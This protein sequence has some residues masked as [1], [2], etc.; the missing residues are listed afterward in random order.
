MAIGDKFTYS[1]LNAG[2]LKK[3][4]DMADK[5]YGTG[6]GGGGSGGGN[7]GQ[8]LALSGDS[9]LNSYNSLR[10][11]R[12]GSNQADAAWAASGIAVWANA[13]MGWPFEIIEPTRIGGGKIQHIIH[14][15]KYY[16]E[17]QRPDWVFTLAGANDITSN[18][19]YAEMIND[20]KTLI[21]KHLRTTKNLVVISIL[22]QGSDEDPSYIMDQSVADIVEQTNA[23][24]KAYCKTEGIYYADL[25][26]EF[27]HPD[28]NTKA[29]SHYLRD[30]VHPDA[31]GA[32]VGG[33]IIKNLLKDENLTPRHF[34]TFP[35]YDNTPTKP[36][37]LGQRNYLIPNGS[38]GG[39]ANPNNDGTNGQLKDASITSSTGV[40]TS[41]K[42][43]KE[44]GVGS[45]L[46]DKLPADEDDIDQTDW[47]Q[48]MVLGGSTGITEYK[49]YQSAG[50]VCFNQFDY[51]K[52]QCEA[53]Y[54]LYDSA[55]GPTSTY[56]PFQVRGFA[57]GATT[58]SKIST[59][60]YESGQVIKDFPFN[61]NHPVRDIK[62]SFLSPAIMINDATSFSLD[63]HFAVGPGEVG[64]FK[65]RHAAAYRVENPVARK[66]CKGNIQIDM[67]QADQIGYYALGTEQ[68]EDLYEGLIVWQNTAAR[69]LRLPQYISG[70][71][72]ITNKT[73]FDL[74]IET[75]TQTE[76]SEVPV[77]LANNKTQMI[78]MNGVEAMPIAPA[79]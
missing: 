56:L 57:G 37:Y 39:S 33:S 76:R 26:A 23:W 41:W 50:Y 51:Y 35:Q 64:I 21:T 65:Y 70:I 1:T 18:I 32:Y 66:L 72:T 49:A 74:N 15:S 5:V 63:L 59:G 67:D 61:A 60:F 55:F 71:Y 8:L 27:I 9:I 36:G 13:L 46:I 24:L 38:S 53:E 48:V 40:P 6:G 45:C 31:V 28:T 54:T 30:G 12:S 19:Q 7:G 44:A 75:A 4:N 10:N 14:E 73:G 47:V 69:V 20:L 16:V 34:G 78:Q 68:A 25:Y 79:V 29:K 52:V 11:D 58:M 3:L 22:P 17:E 2:N 42:F 77:L 62:S 43:D